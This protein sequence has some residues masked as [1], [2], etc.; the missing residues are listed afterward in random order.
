MHEY[1]E[2]ITWAKLLWYSV[3]A[4]LFMYLNIP[5]EQLWLLAMLMIIDIITGM[6]KQF[7]IDPQQISSRAL[8]LWVTKKFT[9]VLLF[10]SLAIAIKVLWLD[11]WTY[12]KAIISVLT[13]SEVYSTIQ[14][15]YTIRTWKHLPEFDIIS[16]FIKW[17]WKTIQDR[18]LDITKNNK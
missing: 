17:L 6:W 14:N 10:L 3:F 18:L 13:V 12:V 7:T 9:V 4:S 2:I 5:Q 8:S 16:L 1:S 11:P 15:V